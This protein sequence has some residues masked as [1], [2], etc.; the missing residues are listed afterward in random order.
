M[1][2]DT[3]EVSENISSSAQ[4]AD[5]I[6]NGLISKLNK[7]GK[8]DQGNTVFKIKE[9]LQAKIDIETTKKGD[10]YLLTVNG[11]TR[12]QTWIIIAT[13]PLLFIGVGFLVILMLLIYKGKPKK[14]ILE[15]MQST[16]LQFENTAS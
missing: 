5:E 3:F 4:T 15:C 2:W 12:V 1:S 10:G 13:I 6:K 16:K 8:V 14:N 11:V 9:G 7:V